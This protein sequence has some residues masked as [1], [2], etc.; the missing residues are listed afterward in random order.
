MVGQDRRLRNFKEA[1][2]AYQY[3]FCWNGAIRCPRKRGIYPLT[4]KDQVQGPETACDI[5][6]L[7]LI[8]WEMVTGRPAFEN[9]RDLYDYVVRKISLPQRMGSNAFYDFSTK[10]LAPSAVARPTSLEAAALP[11]LQSDSFGNAGPII[12][13]KGDKLVL[14][15][16][17]GLTH[18]I[19]ATGNDESERTYATWTT[20]STRLTQQDGGATYGTLDLSIDFE[21]ASEER[22]SRIHILATNSY[23]QKKYDEAEQLLREA[24]NGR[25]SILGK[26]HRD[27]IY[28]EYWLAE[29]LYQREI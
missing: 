3:N 9:G 2:A 8:S 11:W 24:V 18:E 14:D 26:S 13:I 20:K 5:W 12:Q 23:E 29:V 15:G 25:T 28:S 17:S 7:G 27:T 22:L 16:D 19:E 10:T 21:E 1:A 6:S 4:D